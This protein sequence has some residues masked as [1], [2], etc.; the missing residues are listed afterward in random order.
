M[1]R[2]PHS[3]RAIAIGAI[4][5]AL[6]A[7][8][9]A[10]GCADASV[11]ASHPTWCPPS[12]SA[13]PAP[14]PPALAVGHWPAATGAPASAATATPSGPVLDGDAFDP[15]RLT[16]VLDDPRLATVKDDVAHEAWTKATQ[17]LAAA[18]AASPAPS[19]SDALAWRFQLGH[20]RVLAGDP[21]GGA[22]AFDEAS[23]APWTLADHARLQAAVLYA[24][25]GQH[26]AALERLRALGAPLVT[27]GDAELAFADALSGKGDV[28]GAAAHFRAYLALSAR[29]PQWVAITL[30]FAKMLVGHPG[31][32]HAEEAFALARKVADESPNGN[33]AGEAREIEQKALA[34]LP[35]A[36]RARLEH[37]TDVELAA[38]AKALLGSQQTREA[39]R[40]ADTVLRPKGAAPKAPKHGK[41]LHSKSAVGRPHAP[42][43]E[44]P[45]L[46]GPAPPSVAPPGVPEEALCEAWAVRGEALSKLKR[47]A[48]AA[49]AHTEALRHC[50]GDRRAEAL[51]AAGKALASAGRA[52]DASV[53]FAELEHDFPQHR[54]ADDARLRGARATL[55]GGDE[56]RA[57]AMLEKMADD[58]P[59]GDMV[60][61]GLG[62]LALRHVEKHAWAAAIPVL[63]KAAARAPRDR[64]YW[65]AGRAPYYL[66][67]AR[68]ETGAVAQGLETLAGVI[69][70]YPLS[71]YMTLAYARLAD[72]DASA[73]ARA[74]EEAVRKEPEG[75]FTLARSPVFAEPGFA[76]AVELVRQGEDKLARAELDR[77]GM[78]AR[79]APAE[80]LYAAAFLF[81]RAGSV[82]AS[83][84][85]LRSAYAGGPPTRVEAMEWLEHYPAGRW[86]AVWEIAYPRP[87]LPVV[88]G[89]AKRQGIPEALAYAIMREESAFDPRVVSPAAAYGLMQLIV[90]TARRMAR[91]PLNLKADEDTLKRPEVNVPLGC[92][93]LGVLR[94]QFPDNP[95]LAI[96]GYNAGANA[97]KRWLVDRPGE[98]FDLFVEHIPYDETRLYTKRVITSLAAYEFLYGRDQPSEALRAPLPASPGARPAV[99]AP[100]P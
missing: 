76:R 97:P 19:A 60:A 38:R 72:R 14:P 46:D 8:P 5:V 48:E 20:L 41:K 77:L 21:V 25:A 65:L 29:P 88:S 87:F 81:A 22:R 33:G 91:P 73:A 26:D 80:L 67:R 39:L 49:E 6:G 83:H 24:K 58:Y 61:E 74:L 78:T 12:C 13:A 1:L 10:A 4:A 31:E 23:A 82:T 84:G 16:T 17:D 89:E 30:R 53:R 27:S 70:D 44:G 96:P 7:T 18:L 99:A 2:R 56:A 32:A 52:Q 37:P 75:A 98:D 35:H 90:P 40:V 34:T 55:E 92:R 3:V 43:A 71:F 59:N 69:R 54:L 86:R 94:G 100:E 62:E 50:Q 9:L 57:T 63:E 64:A 79:T 42:P 36:K 28:D 66:G 15:T 47:K 68:L 93:Y 51:Y 95:L 11:S 45:D 85:V